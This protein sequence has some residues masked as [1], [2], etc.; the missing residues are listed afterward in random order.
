[1]IPLNLENAM[2]SHNLHPS[3]ENTDE[4]VVVLEVSIHWESGDRGQKSSS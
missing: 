3:I 2:T 1:M 4:G